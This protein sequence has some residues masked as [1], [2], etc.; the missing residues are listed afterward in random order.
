MVL[1]KTKR[2]QK[3]TK[4]KCIETKNIMVEAGKIM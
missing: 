1:N 2:K 3:K 4:L